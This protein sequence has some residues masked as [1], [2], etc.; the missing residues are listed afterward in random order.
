MEMLRSV[1]GLGEGEEKRYVKKSKHDGKNYLYYIESLS[2]NATLY[3][4]AS[5]KPQALGD[6]EALWLLLRIIKNRNN[7]RVHQGM[8]DR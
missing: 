4:K 3:G 6:Q 5:R 1:F 2:V 7:I 8:G